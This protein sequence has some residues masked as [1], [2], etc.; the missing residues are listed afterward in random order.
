MESFR[1]FVENAVLAGGEGG[2]LEGGSSTSPLN[3]GAVSPLAGGSLEGGV[4]VTEQF[5]RLARGARRFASNASSSLNNTENLSRFFTSF[6]LPF[7]F[8]V[9]LSPGLLLN[10]PPNS[11]TECVTAVPFPVN[12]NGTCSGGVYTPGT[13]DGVTAV[14]MKT[15][16]EQRKKCKDVGTSGY[17]GIGAILVH[18]VVF[19]ILVNLAVYGFKRGLSRS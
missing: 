5:N 13:S 2:L 17:T 7:A 19:V 8:F 3:G 4:T 18:A 9:I 14:N 1:N 16:C 10:L 15:I 6:V 12:A 11:D